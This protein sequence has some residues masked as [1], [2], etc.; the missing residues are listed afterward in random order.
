MFDVHCHVFNLAT[1][2]NGFLGIRIPF[3]NWFLKTLE[4]TLHKIKSKTDTDKLSNFAYFID[5][6]TNRNIENIAQKLFDYYRDIEKKTIFCPLMM[7]MRPG[8]KGKQAV[9]YFT[10]IDDMRNLRNKYPDKLLPFIAIDPN[11]PKAYEIFLKAFSPDYNFFGVKLY[12]SLGY[13]PTHPRLMNI[14]E[15]CEEK[16]IPVTAHCS[17]A[18]VHT[19]YRHI[20]NIR[21]R[22]LNAKGEIVEYKD[23]KWFFRKKKYANYFNHPKNW[24]PVLE[25]FPKLKLN[26]AHF[27]SSREWEKL[28]KAK[29]NNWA[30]EIIYLMA[31]Y[32]N[33][34]ADFS[35][36]IY[37]EN[38]FDTFNFLLKEDELLAKRALYGSDFY[39]VVTEGHFRKI[40]NNFILAMDENVMQQIACENPRKFLFG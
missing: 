9:D 30:Y 17:G 4:H 32:E 24:I 8:I 25:T 12:P 34:Y 6:G 35:M 5:F 27:G 21:G 11:N 13:L 7:D 38:L 14:L 33:V 31:R 37:D 18:S 23:N 22:K 36:N 40:K 10:Q 3:K 1:V 29:K 39:M 2:P 28:V 19:S 16:R 15:I 26:L 20:K